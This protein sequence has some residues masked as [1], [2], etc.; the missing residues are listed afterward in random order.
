MNPTARLLW[1]HY[2][3]AAAFIGYCAATTSNSGSTWHAI[4]LFISSLLL[5]V[6][7]ARESV[8]AH[9]R[10]AAA[11]AEAVRVE[12]AVRMRALLGRDDADMDGG[13]CERW[14]T[15]AGAEHDPRHCAR[16]GQS[17]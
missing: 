7:L 6:A 4:G 5:L 3:A 15:S 8:A 17:A 11:R 2:L 16:K 1:W 14:W 9:Q 12:R 10:R 13:C